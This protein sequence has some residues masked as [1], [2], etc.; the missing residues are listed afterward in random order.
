MSTAWSRLFS[1]WQRYELGPLFRDYGDKAKTIIQAGC[2]VYVVR[3]YCVEFS[4][5]C[6]ACGGQSCITGPYCSLA[7][8][9]IVAAQCMGPSMLPT[10]NTRG[11]VLMLEHFSTQ[12]GRITV[13]A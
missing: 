1:L 9:V 4:V 7:V 5:V 6:T 10:F 13:G 8:T 11:D 3:E 12:F 2:L